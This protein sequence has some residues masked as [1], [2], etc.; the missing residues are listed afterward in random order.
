MS[1]RRLSSGDCTEAYPDWCADAQSLCFAS[2][3][4]GAW[5]IWRTGERGAAAT[6]VTRSGGLVAAEADDRRSVCFSKGPGIPGLWRVPLQGGVEVPLCPSL[7]GD[8]WGNWALAHGGVYYLVRDPEQRPTT[9]LEFCDFASSAVR[10]IARLPGV[11]ASGDS[12]LS[13]APDART[14]AYAQLDRSSARIVLQH[15]FR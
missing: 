4:D 2:D 15:E 11:P 10:E 3:R 6:R 14:V 12:G 7:P 8:M 9:R 5:Q 1:V 13:L